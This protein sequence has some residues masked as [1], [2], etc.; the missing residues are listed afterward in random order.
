[1][2]VAGRGIHWISTSL[3][4]LCTSLK[5]AAQGIYLHISLD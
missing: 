5:E 1:V 4:Q 3:T 2:I